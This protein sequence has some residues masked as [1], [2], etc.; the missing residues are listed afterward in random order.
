MHSRMKRHRSDDGEG[1]WITL[2]KLTCP[3][4]HS[5]MIHPAVASDGHTYERAAIRKWLL[6]VRMTSPLTNEQ[7]ENRMLRPN[8]ALRDVCSAAF[9][10]L[11]DHAR[12]D[13]CD[14][15]LQAAELEDAQLEKLCTNVSLSETYRMCPK[16][17]AF[18]M[19]GDTVEDVAR[20]IVSS[21][22]KLSG[23]YSSRLVAKYVSDDLLDH[24]FI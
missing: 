23:S 3:V 6:G 14:A 24:G 8:H 15:A 21:L 17:W 10:T 4:T 13:V 19:D 12:S 20:L 16:R 7:L 1:V 9:E 22:R 11:S 2:D 18:S 5:L